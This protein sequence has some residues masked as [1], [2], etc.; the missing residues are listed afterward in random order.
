MLAHKPIDPDITNI[1]LADILH[2]GF[3]IEN[4]RKNKNPSNYNL[5]LKLYPFPSELDNTETINQFIDRYKS[6]LFPDAQYLKTYV[7]QKKNIII[8]FAEIDKKNT[9]FTRDHHMERFLVTDTPGYAVYFNNHI[10]FYS[11]YLVTKGAKPH[12]SSNEDKANFSTQGVSAFYRELLNSYRH[13]LQELKGVDKK[14][15]YFTDVKNLDKTRKLVLLILPKQPLEFK[16]W[17]DLPMPQDPNNIFLTSLLLIY[18]TEYNLKSG[19][20]PTKIPQID[21]PNFKKLFVKNNTKVLEIASVVYL[22]R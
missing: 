7:F 10:P 14:Y 16:N 8:K 22:D 2:L 21:S 9:V 4:P 3:D 20:L 18:H 11:L 6:D 15:Y 1:N 19:A 5:Y 12:F 17:R 13:N